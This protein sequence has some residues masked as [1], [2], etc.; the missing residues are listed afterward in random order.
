MVDWVG[1][2]N[3]GVLEIISDT[4]FPLC[5][6]TL[7]G[8]RYKNMDK[9]AYC[10]SKELIYSKSPNKCKSTK[11][12]M[13]KLMIMICFIPSRSADKYGQTVL[14]ALVRDWDADTIRFAEEQCVDLDAQDK[15]GVSAL[16]LAAAMD[17]KESTEEL[18]KHG[19][20]PTEYSR[21]S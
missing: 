17:L 21:G 10:T 6:P 4:S 20:E 16:H 5:N 8:G 7:K 18:L 19:G 12:C 3:N 14:H 2:S 1:V 15:F 13:Q 11:V 9:K